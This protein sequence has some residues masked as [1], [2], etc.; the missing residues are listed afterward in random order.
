M[1]KIDDYIGPNGVRTRTFTDE[2]T[3]KMFVRKD[4]DI[5]GQVEYATKLRNADQY[6]KDGIKKSMMHVCHIPDVVVVELLGI[7]VNVFKADAKT[8]VA[9]LK[10]LHKEHLMTTNLQV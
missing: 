5:E 4:Q 1:D 8:I 7:G 3:G 10:K 9:G 2:A 6:S